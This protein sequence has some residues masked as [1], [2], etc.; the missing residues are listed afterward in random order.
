ML[1]PSSGRTAGSSPLGFVW[2][3][4]LVLVL[5]AGLAPVANAQVPL[6]LHRRVDAPG[7]EA[8][9]GQ[10]LPPNTTVVAIPYAAAQPHTLENADVSREDLSRL[11][12]ERLRARDDTVRVTGNSR[13]DQ[14]FPTTPESGELLYVLA[15]TPTGSLYESYVYTGSGFVPG[16]DAI[17]SGRM[18]MGPVPP[19]PARRYRAS[20]RVYRQE[21]GARPGTATRDGGSQAE[22]PD[23]RPGDAAGASQGSQSA[24][25]QHAAQDQPQ[26]AGASNASS[27]PGGTWTFL[28]GALLG[29]V[30]GGGFLWYLSAGR[31]EELE[32]E[33]NRLQRRINRQN[34]TEFRDGTGA[35]PS[36]PP[37]GSGRSPAAD[38]D[39]LQEENEE[40]R[41]RNQRLRDE[42]RE[43]R[44]YVENLREERS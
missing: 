4:L 18:T 3:S 23:D 34:D 32:V 40:L 16:F 26:N 42:I 14:P 7:E 20:F 10:P 41:E 44:R 22:I 35:S 21:T 28:I 13:T 25:G 37:D 6:E 11:L 9:Q 27:S 17:E 1:F 36:S 31:I 29:G 12:L 43:I 39:R 8:Y 2:T 15:R 30:V 33:R 24:E 19:E 5:L 38:I